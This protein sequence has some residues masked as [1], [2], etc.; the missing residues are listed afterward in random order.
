MCSQLVVLVEVINYSD[1]AQPSGR[2]RASRSCTPRPVGVGQEGGR[3]RPGPLG[4]RPPSRRPK[5]SA[6]WPKVQGTVRTWFLLVVLL[7]LHS[8]DVWG[9]QAKTQAIASSGWPAE[10]RRL[11]PNTHVNP[12]GPPLTTA[13]VL[14]SIPQ[15]P[16]NRS[17][18][19]RWPSL[20]RATLTWLRSFEARSRL[21]TLR[22][23][24]R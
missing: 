9:V 15:N 12:R 11:D 1:L 19:A 16:G 8:R 13:W 2:L 17:R 18:F 4:G 10:R 22:A 6:C 14:P 7:A 3:S 5:L 24:G 20:S 21:P 23:K